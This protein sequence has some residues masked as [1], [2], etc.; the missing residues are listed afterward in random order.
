MLKDR[1]FK[2]FFIPLLGLY[3]PYTAG[4]IVF[5][6]LTTVQGVLSV[7]FFIGVFYFVWQSA[8]KLMSYLRAHKPV[9]RNIFIK[10]SVLLVTTVL[11]GVSVVFLSSGLWQLIVLK[12]LMLQPL[13]KVAV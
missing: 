10:L 13:L 2:L 1:T 7:V 9:R 11:Y 6:Q 3:I 8:I 4:L 5:Q 12:K